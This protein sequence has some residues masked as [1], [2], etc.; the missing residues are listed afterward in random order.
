LVPIALSF[1]LRTLSGL[2]VHAGLHQLALW[3]H[4]LK[5]H[6]LLLNLIEVDLFLID[7]FGF[8]DSFELFD[9]LF[10]L[11]VLLLLHDKLPDKKLSI[12]FLSLEVLPQLGILLNEQPIL[13]I[14]PLSNGSNKL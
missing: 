7:L 10:V 13:I 5:V 3:R 8:D 4:I 2:L 12:I 14:D 9:F 1:H 11:L 6:I